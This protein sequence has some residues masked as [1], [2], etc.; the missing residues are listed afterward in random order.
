MAGGCGMVAL[1]CG[2]SSR[3][4]EASRA[5]VF[6]AFPGFSREMRARRTPSRTAGSIPCYS[7]D[8]LCGV[9][10]I[11]V[12]WQPRWQRPQLREPRGAGGS[13]CSCLEPALA[14]V[15]TA[16]S[17][18]IQTTRAWPCPGS[19]RMDPAQG[20]TRPERLGAIGPASRHGALP[21]GHVAA[22]ASPARERCQCREHDRA[23][24]FPRPAAQ[25]GRER[26][27]R[28]EEP[29]TRTRARHRPPGGRCCDSAGTGRGAAGGDGSSGA[30]PDTGM[31]PE[32]SAA[33]RP[34]GDT[35]ARPSRLRP[36]RGAR[37]CPAR[38][39]PA[40]NRASRG[41]AGACQP[42]TVPSVCVG[43]PNWAGDPSAPGSPHR[44]RLRTPK[45]VIN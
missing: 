17:M 35:C 29:G 15:P 8:T 11:T 9:T 2:K 1:P 14:R 7:E 33:P 21:P 40:S 34:S 26:G 30:V 16:F 3:A 25:T 42:D 6:W 28:D 37:R 12:G 41:A 27:R 31:A 20:R 36:H 32:A 19:A 38:P 24:I 18:R 23:E 4:H 13:G 39:D 10:M 44:C 45:A 43:P 5:S 22:A